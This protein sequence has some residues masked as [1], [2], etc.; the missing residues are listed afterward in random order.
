MGASNNIAVVEVA[1]CK[2]ICVDSV[3]IAQNYWFLSDLRQS[4]TLVC[5]RD[6]DDHI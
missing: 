3:A 6:V 5:E 2:N 1:D 4:G